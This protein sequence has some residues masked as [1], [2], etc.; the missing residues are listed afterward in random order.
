VYG[1]ALDCRAFANVL[2]LLEAYQTIAS[3]AMLEQL[4]QIVAHAATT[5]YTD[6]IKA[7]ILPGSDQWSGHVA[8]RL[9]GW[10]EGWRGRAR[11]SN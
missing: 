5:E 7:G 3:Q 8:G 2:T 9:V 4:R 11:P 6:M 1:Q 10:W